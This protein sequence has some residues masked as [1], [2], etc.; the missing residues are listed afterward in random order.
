MIRHF[1][2]IMM[3]A[4]LETSAEN[5]AATIKPP[6][7]LIP[8]A[9]EPGKFKFNQCMAIS[10]PKASWRNFCAYDD[11]LC[12]QIT[13]WN[14]MATDTE[15]KFDSDEDFSDLLQKLT[16]DKRVYKH[17][18]WMQRLSNMSDAEEDD[19]PVTSS[20]DEEQVPKIKNPKSKI[21]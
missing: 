6:K 21:H 13:E 20:S 11:P 7:F 8:I 19:E 12:Q 2:D 4:E 14:K 3:T 15:H 10:L 5:T 18:P 9:D 16:A 1:N 17:L